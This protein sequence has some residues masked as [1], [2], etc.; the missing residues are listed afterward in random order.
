MSIEVRVSVEN[1]KSKRF[2]VEKEELTL[3]DLRTIMKEKWAAVGSNF[4]FLTNED[5]L[6]RDRESKYKLSK[7]KKDDHIE[8]VVRLQENSDDKKKTAQ[9]EKSSAKLAQEKV[10]GELIKNDGSH[11]SDKETN[12]I[13]LGWDD[14]APLINKTKFPK[15]FRVTKN[16]LQ[17]VNDP[18][19]KLSKEVSMDE[20]STSGKH[21]E[22]YARSYFTQWEKE[23]NKMSSQDIAASIKM[24]VPLLS[25]K[26]GLDIS[27]GTTSESQTQSKQTYLYMVAQR[28]VPRMKV[29]LKEQTIQVTDD[30]KKKVE[31]AV[32]AKDSATLRKVF[33]KHGY[34]VPTT[35]IM[36]GKIIAE[37]TQEFSEK[38]DQNKQTEEFK[39]AVSGEMNRNGLTAEGKA[40]S[41][42]QNT[43]QSK[44][45]NAHTSSQYNLYAVGGDV[46]LVSSKPGEWTSSLT[47]E[48]WDIISYEDFMPITDFLPQD[49][50]DKCEKLLTP[51]PLNKLPRVVAEEMKNMVEAVAW[52]AAHTVQNKPDKKR[53]ARNQEEN[54]DKHARKVI[55]ELERHGI[56]LSPALL[57]DIKDAAWNIAWN[58]AYYCLGKREHGKEYE[59]KFNQ[60]W[61]SMK[62]SNE[63]TQ[64]LADNIIEMCR[65]GAWHRANWQKAEQSKDNAL[66]EVAGKNHHDWE[67][68]YH[69]IYR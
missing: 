37:K 51:P 45:T 26:F 66:R 60:L 38:M 25:A 12:F 58:T 46:G 33:E 30:F 3:R 8:V 5:Q 2:P 1:G 65:N 63:V 17:L 54:F 67:E 14:L 11:K 20:L 55:S 9:N 4:L 24:S 64:D 49:L 10:S 13:N 40:S 69:K 31:K 21:Y 44:E 59:R 50:K 56:Y 43:S 32:E 34:F 48:K 22:D 47:A 6:P 41:N 18:G 57:K 39:G 19:I 35:Y 61:E 27:Y 68:F 62:N 7:F 52:H 42:R 16:G 15:A 36:G 23:S 29:V 28:F 53:D